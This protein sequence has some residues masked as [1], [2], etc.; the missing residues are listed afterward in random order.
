MQFQDVVSMALL[1]PMGQ[2]HGRHFG[3]RPVSGQLVGLAYG[4]LGA[5][6]LWGLLQVIW[7]ASWIMLFF[8]WK[9][10]HPAARP[11]GLFPSP[12]AE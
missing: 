6:A 11:K 7:L 2:L 3:F 12:Q 1:R 10:L 8:M 5:P 9:R 4:S